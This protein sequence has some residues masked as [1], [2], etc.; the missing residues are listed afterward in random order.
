MTFVVERNS[1]RLLH[2]GIHSV[3]CRMEF[4]PSYIK[5]LQI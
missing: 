2:V 3:D 5:Q 1:F 4:I